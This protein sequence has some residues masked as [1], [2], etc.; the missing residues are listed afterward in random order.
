MTELSARMHMTEYQWFCLRRQ[1]LADTYK[2][3]KLFPDGVSI[4]PEKHNG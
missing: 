4:L 1:M 2:A 3:M